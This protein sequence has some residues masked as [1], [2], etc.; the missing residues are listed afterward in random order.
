V[1]LVFGLNLPQFSIGVV[2]VVLKCVVIVIVLVT[3][4][5][6][7]IRIVDILLTC[8]ILIFLGFVKIMRKLIETLTCENMK[9]NSLINCHFIV[10]VVILEVDCIY[11]LLYLKL[12]SP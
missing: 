8:R 5:K 12:E 10:S 11:I 1:V 2:V 7:S 4:L 6:L 9:R 3:L